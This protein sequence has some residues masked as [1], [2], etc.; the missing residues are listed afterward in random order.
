MHDSGTYHACQR[1]G[2]EILMY[3]LNLF[4]AAVGRFGIS[5]ETERKP[6]GRIGF[7]KEVNK[8]PYGSKHCMRRYFNLNH[9][10]RI[11]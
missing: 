4:S 5:P 1:C 8:L 7:G 2:G 9:S 3:V 11:S 6:L 10:P